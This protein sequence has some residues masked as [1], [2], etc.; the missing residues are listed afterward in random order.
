MGAPLKEETGSTPLGKEAT[1][2]DRLQL[3]LQLLLLVPLVL[4]AQGQSSDVAVAEP[5]ASP[6]GPPGR[7]RRGPNERREAA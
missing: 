1:G 2:I 4:T 6:G 5:L 7:P 3:S